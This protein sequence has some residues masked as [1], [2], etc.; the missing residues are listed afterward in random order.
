MNL[1]IYISAILMSGCHS[2]GISVTDL[3]ESGSEE[4]SENRL[5]FSNGSSFDIAMIPGKSVGFYS[6]NKDGNK[7]ITLRY[8]LSSPLASLLLKTI[9]TFHQYLKDMQSKM[10][11]EMRKLEMRDTGNLRK[12][13][14]I[15]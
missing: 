2:S 7:D 15:L 1:S 12:Q 4:V 11:L 5:T 8:D 14:V 13:I 10:F 3:P 6:T 9:K